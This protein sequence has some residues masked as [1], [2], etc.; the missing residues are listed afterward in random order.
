MPQRLRQL[1]LSRRNC[2]RCT[3]WRHAIDFPWR[4]RARGKSLDI[5]YISNV[6]NVCKTELERKRYLNLT[7]DQKY[8]R[9][10][11]ANQL[12]KERRLKM[13][14]ELA[15]QLSAVIER[16]RRIEALNDRIAALKQ[17]VGRPH[18]QIKGELVLDILPVR[19]FLVKQRKW[20][21][22][23]ATLASR[24]DMDASR[25]DRLLNG[26]SHSTNGGVTPIR[27]I[28][29]A[30]VDQIL[31]KLEASERVEDLYPELVA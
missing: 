8:D 10:A 22:S 21:G 15:S 6:C 18:T 14:A 29:L 2:K 30:L 24:L 9:G 28:S 7:A 31:V 26:Y 23:T 19:M 12:A 11:R 4:W 5:P 20:H 17:R 13:E 1:N 16:E 25:L 3:R 27:S